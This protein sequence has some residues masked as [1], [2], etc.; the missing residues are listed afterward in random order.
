M[1][2]LM[3]CPQIRPYWSMVIKF[4]KEVLKE[5]PAQKDVYTIVFNMSNMAQGKMMSTE[6]CA[7]ARH[8]FDRFWR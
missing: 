4:I 5:T 1:L 3:E 6:A 8:A 7:F 2:H